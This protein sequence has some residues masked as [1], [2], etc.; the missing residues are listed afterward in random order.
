MSDHFDV[1]PSKTA[2]PLL[3]AALVML[4]GMVAALTFFF[5]FSPDPIM[6]ALV[7]GGA[8]A[9]VWILLYLATL[10]SAHW[11][12]FYEGIFRLKK[13]EPEYEPRI[14]KDSETE[15]GNKKPPSVDAVREMKSD[16]I[17][18]W[19]PSAGTQKPPRNPSK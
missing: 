7:L 13:K 12:D 11:R 19:V 9:S 5:L 4:L 14:R 3:A 17:R 2:A 8:W 18:T 1:R 10:G 6:A 15:Y 16:T